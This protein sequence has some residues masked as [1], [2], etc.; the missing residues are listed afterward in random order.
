MAERWSSADGGWLSG[1]CHQFN[2]ESGGLALVLS[3][4]RVGV[5]VRRVEGSSFALVVYAGTTMSPVV[6]LAQAK[7]WLS[8]SEASELAKALGFA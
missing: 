6:V 1:E 5:D 2:D 4:E 7:P 3:V 8:D